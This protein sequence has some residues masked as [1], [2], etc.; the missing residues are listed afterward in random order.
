LLQ[1]ED[2]TGEV[3]QSVL[4]QDGVSAEFSGALIGSIDGNPIVEGV[5]GEGSEFMLGVRKTETLPKRVVESVANV[6]RSIE[7]VLGPAVKIE[8]AFD[9]S[10]TWILQLHLTEVAVSRSTIVPGEA[11][12]FHRF[13]TERGINELRGLIASLQGGADGIELTRGVGITSHFGDLLR[14]AKIPAR[15]AVEL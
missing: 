5:S 6:Y 10:V 8:W 13:D 9:G 3:L 1:T 15:V 11:L 7:E 4:S 12:R 14:R 2:P